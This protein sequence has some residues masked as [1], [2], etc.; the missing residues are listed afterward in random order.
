MSTRDGLAGQVVGVN[1]GVYS[2][3]GKNKALLLSLRASTTW[4]ARH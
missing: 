2:A 1:E 3:V 4:D